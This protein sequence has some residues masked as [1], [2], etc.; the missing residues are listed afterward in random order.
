M[1]L[2]RTTLYL[3]ITYY[4]SKGILSVSRKS[5]PF[6]SLRFSQPSSDFFL[7]ACFVETD[8]KHAVIHKTSGIPYDFTTKFPLMKLVISS[9]FP[10]RRHSY[11]LV[12]QKS[13]RSAVRMVVIYYL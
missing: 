4:D 9:I 7:S 13:P 1:V 5:H 6:I 3:L 11:V 12:S 2:S 8:S 10:T